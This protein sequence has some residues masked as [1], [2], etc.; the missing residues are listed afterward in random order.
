MVEQI[1]TNKSDMQ[2]FRMEK[3]K[4]ACTDFEALFYSIILKTGRSESLE[5]DLIKK[6]EGEKIFTEMLDSEIAKTVAE[7]TEGGLKDILFNYFKENLSFDNG[8]NNPTYGKN[9][10]VF[11]GLVKNILA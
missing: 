9:Y 11:A 4:K 5:S 1:N 2:N 8:K 10:A 7:N 3:L 6:S